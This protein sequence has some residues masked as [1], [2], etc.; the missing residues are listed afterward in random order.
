MRYAGLVRRVRT[1][2]AI[3]YSAVNNR[4]IVFCLI[5]WLA[6]MTPHCTRDP[7]D[8]YLVV[9]IRLM[10]PL[11]CRALGMSRI[12]Q[13][14][15]VSRILG[16]DLFLEGFLVVCLGRAHR[17]LSPGSCIFLSGTPSPPQA[18]SCYHHEVDPKVAARRGEGGLLS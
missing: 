9:P 6:E 3:V 14:P 11:T 15:Q 17:Q 13:T 4:R 18:L 12:S 2:L 7:P 1:V 8:H 16:R 5:A 10:G